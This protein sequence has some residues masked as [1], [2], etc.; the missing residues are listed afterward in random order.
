VIDLTL[1][2]LATFVSALITGIAGFAFGLI[3]AAHMMDGVVPIL[4]FGIMPSNA[5]ERNWR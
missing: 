1:F 3:A 2:P 5:G 4:A